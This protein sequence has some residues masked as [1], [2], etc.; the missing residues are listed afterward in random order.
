MKYLIIVIVI[1]AGLVLAWSVY[2]F[3]A[4]D[5]EFAKVTGSAEDFALALESELADKCQAPPGYTTEEWQEHMSHH[6]NLYQECFNQGQLSPLLDYQDVGPWD[7]A[8]ML[9]A[10]DFTL[11]DVHIPEQAHIPGTDLFIPYDEINEKL[12]LLPEDKQAKIVLYCRSGS[13]SRLAAEALVK[14]GYANVYNLAG[15][16]NAWQAEGYGAEET[17]LTN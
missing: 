9:E 3:V 12:S 14:A 5:S 7:L 17:S 4:S 6:P 16:L 10:K 8:T 2:D 13:M 11:V 1:L 15:G